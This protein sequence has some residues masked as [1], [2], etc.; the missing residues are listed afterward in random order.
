MY[1][2]ERLDVW[3]QSR[4][5]SGLIYGNTRKFPGSEQFGLS[6]Q[7]R[8]AAVSISSNIAEGTSRYSPK[9]QARYYEMAYGS[10]MELLNQVL[11][12]HD[13]GFLPAQEVQILRSEIDGVAIRL[14]RL[15]NKLI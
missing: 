2:F 7:M 15:R 9:E 6:L 12:S 5:L 14:S 1:G 10:C 4:R 13:Q 3:Q 11:I 8:R